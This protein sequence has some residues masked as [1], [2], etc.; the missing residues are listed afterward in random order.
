MSWPRPILLPLLPV[1]ILVAALGVTWVVWDHEQQASRK[2]LLS[3]FDI[4]LRETVSRV[5]LRM[6]T[7]EQML[8]GVQSLYVVTSEMDRDSFSNYVSSLNL[9]ANFAG[10]Q[11]IGVGKW[12]PAMD[13]DTH[14]VAMRRIGPANYSVKPDGR[15]EN[16]VP[17]IQREP[18]YGNNRARLGFDM[19][20][21]P[22]R[23]LAMEKAR[24]SGSPAV[25]GKLQLLVDIGTDSRPG[26]IMY[27][28]IY[29][30][31][32]PHD[33]VAER[34][35]HLA[36]WVYATF[37][38][39]DVMASL[40]GVLPPGLA[41][42]IYDGVEPSA[43]ALTYRSPEE[44]GRGLPA[45]M[46]AN[47]YLVIAGHNWTLSMSATDDFRGRFR[48]NAE[49][50]IA[51]T[52]IGLSLLLA[53]LSWLLV[54]GR[55]R[56]M[57]LAATMTTELRESEE[58][59][60]AIA[61]CMVNWEVWWGLDGKP[62]WINPSVKEYTGYT[63][64]E[65][66]AMPDLAT[67]LIHP[68]DMPRV[69]PEFRKALQG[70]RGDDLEFRSV[71]K[72]GSLFWLSISWA[73]IC[74]AKGAFTGFRTSGRDITERKQ[75]EAE[76][77]IAAVA[78]DS[79]EGMMITDAECRILR[80][81]GAFT[82]STGYAAAEVVG[83]TPRMLQSGRHDAAFF[84]EM[85][86]AIRNSGGWQGEIWDR[87]KNGEV[88]PKWLTISA[89]TGDDGVVTHYIGTHHDITER[90]ISEERIKELAFFDALTHLPN[91]T[92]LLDRLT[93]AITLSARN[94][95]CGALLFV[96]L[97]HFKTL[98]DTLGHDQGDRLLLQ[99]AQRLAASVREVDTVARVGGDE[100]VVVLGSLS[101]HPQEAASQTEAVGEK[102]L[103]VL[104]KVYQ[105]EDIEY[106][107]T[108]SIGATL[109]QGHQT[110]IDELLKQ[111]DLAMYKA[112]ET[113]R[114]ALRF[115][116]P[117][118]QTA[119]VARATLEAGLRKA[120]EDKQF[121]LHY[122]AQVVDGDTITGSEAL[123][124]WQHPQRGIVLPA[125]FIPM[126]EETGLI[127]PLGDW[128]LETACRQLAL[129]A[130]CPEMAHLTV[131]VNIS[132]QQFR[133]PDFVSKVLG[134][135]SQTGANPSR[136]KLELTES[137]LVD[138]MQ[139]IIQKMYALKIKG[140]F[141]SLDDFG[142]GYSS[143]AYLKRLPLDQLK[144]DHS[145]VRDILF[146][147]NDAAIARTILA[148]A[149]SLGLEVIAEG[150]ET[151][152]QRDFLLRAGCYAYQGNYFCRPLPI[153]GFEEFVRTAGLPSTAIRMRAQGGMP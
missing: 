19:W 68:D 32:Q 140:V 85:W 54:T 90:K 76:L 122:Q 79:R 9:D 80:V 53:L 93:Q 146:D 116:D 17:I 23:R 16:Y 137:L 107:C 47:E 42:A 40:Y 136:L 75:A 102:I 91:R 55:S 51:V 24:D 123:V 35:A 110:S 148:L 113:G 36:G 145:F 46:S 61:D 105:L 60:R 48:R 139:D 152:A 43:A 106:R 64:A 7:Y 119:V 1:F 149:N 59:F 153:E 14:V 150:V 94:E 30:R 78:F 115:F 129:W 109:F 38:M 142:T 147:V 81:N 6:A 58:K 25:S 31:G 72:D 56:A 87:R 117:A 44:G 65:C 12:V 104:S 128:V 21:D 151:K 98:N 95:T 88:Y 18:D 67:A 118:M 20:S 71:R 33:S 83:Q 45:V 29:N 82:E 41:F 99:A 49:L 28:P 143:L 26:F 73:P 52:G 89:V 97:D 11:S 13:K 101:E 133:E 134:I 77:R 3:Q 96:D 5:E 69:A 124:R 39:S 120:I 27:L 103:D 15:R 84:R 86:E 22:E 138:N 10:I 112:K 125:D 135:I 74:D 132:A 57:Q 127:L 114:N 108:A 92:L 62:R 131:A 121:L 8:R 63:V 2:E 130:A 34:R 50:P 37:R 70:L 4:S 66:M 141:F 126:A 144:I 100:F 111:A